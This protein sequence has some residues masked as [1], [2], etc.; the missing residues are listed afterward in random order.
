MPYYE[1]YFLYTFQL[2]PG[3][4]RNRS[5]A[6][7]RIPSLLLTGAPLLRERLFVRCQG[8]Q[9]RLDTGT[10]STSCS[11]SR[12]LQTRRRDCY[13]KLI[14]QYTKIFLHWKPYELRLFLGD[15]CV[16]RRAPFSILKG[17]FYPPILKSA[18]KRSGQTNLCQTS[19]PSDHQTNKQT[20]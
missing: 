11:P 20:H 5:S 3:T 4:R 12:G 18:D 13:C 8:V 7:G 1:I 16:G 9:H 2:H 17:K 19:K 14:I 10:R 15:H 6:L